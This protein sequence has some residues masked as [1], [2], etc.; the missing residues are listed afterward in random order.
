ME[1][2]YSGSWEAI[3]FDGW[4]IHDAFVACRQLGYSGADSITRETAA[5]MMSSLKKVQCKGNEN[6]LGDCDHDGWSVGNC[7]YGYA[8]VLCTGMLGLT[9]SFTLLSLGFRFK[10]GVLSVFTHILEAAWPS[11][12]HVGLAIGRSRIRVPL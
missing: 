7:S 4:D 10:Q 2:H 5:S 12:Q 3:C 1:I 6:T 11:G 9:S 8:G